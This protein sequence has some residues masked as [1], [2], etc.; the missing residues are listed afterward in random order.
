MK[1]DK[2]YKQTPTLG[3]YGSKLKSFF[4]INSTLKKIPLRLQLFYVFSMS[5]I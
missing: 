5:R 2:S 3:G 4:S 1:L